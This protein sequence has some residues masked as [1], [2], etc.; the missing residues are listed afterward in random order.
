M[1]NILATAAGLGL[2][3]PV[4]EMIDGMFD[5]LIAEGKGGLDHAALALAVEALNGTE[6]R[7]TAPERRHD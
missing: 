6:I 2:S 1:K 4:A 5:A 3:L 7:M